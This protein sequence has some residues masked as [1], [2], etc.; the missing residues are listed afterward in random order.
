MDDVKHLN[1]TMNQSEILLEEEDLYT[2]DNEEPK[3]SAPLDISKLMIK[4][5]WTEAFPDRWRARLQIALQTWLSKLEENATVHSIKLMNG[6]SFA[7]VQITPSTALEALKK[8]K[9][10]PLRFKNENKEVTAWICQD[11]ADY[12]NIPQKSLQEENKPPSPE[13]ITSLPQTSA[14]SN[15]GSAASNI[16]LNDTNNIK[17]T[18]TTPERSDGLILCLK[19]RR[20]FR[21]LFRDV[22][23]GLVRPSLVMTWIQIL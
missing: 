16:A 18:E 22:L 21:N 19:P 11:G 8:L 5:D 10:I 4:V 2:A 9:V 15:E 20:T 13:V 7:E 3:P 1:I 14:A 17:T 6:P 12:V 23:V